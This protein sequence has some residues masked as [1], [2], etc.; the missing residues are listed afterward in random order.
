[1]PWY[2]HH[3]DYNTSSKAP[4]YRLNLSNKNLKNLIKIFPCFLSQF[5]D[6]M[7]NFL[8]E[9]YL[10]VTAKWNVWILLITV[11]SWWHCRSMKSMYSSPDIT[12]SNRIHRASKAAVECFCKFRE[13]HHRSFC[14]KK[15]F[16][17]QIILRERF[18]Q[19]R[20]KTLK[21]KFSNLSSKFT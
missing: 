12:L 1:M 2:C 17:N 4:H 16:T 10:G 7:L 9:K 15:V 8:L 3:S 19:W 5:C 18:A 21:L 11:V 20:K 6:I 14:S 13:V